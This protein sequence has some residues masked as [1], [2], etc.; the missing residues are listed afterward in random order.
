[1]AY[2]KEPDGTEAIA[3]IILALLCIG[4]VYWF[5][6]YDQARQM[7]KPYRAVRLANGEV[8]QCRVLF[9]GVGNMR[10]TDLH[11]KGDRII[12]NA[13]NFEVAGD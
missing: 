4:A 6:Q 2:Y 8:L 12:R 13:V 9:G 1:M 7:A 3:G 10:R 5:N 11:C